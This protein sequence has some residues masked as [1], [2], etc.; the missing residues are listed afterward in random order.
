MK[1]KRFIPIESTDVNVEALKRALR[2]M[3]DSGHSK[4]P[5]HLSVMDKLIEAYAVL[6]KI[7]EKDDF[8][9]IIGS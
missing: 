8:R 7:E 1:S 9:R 2:M 5:V 4:M 3:K 6:N